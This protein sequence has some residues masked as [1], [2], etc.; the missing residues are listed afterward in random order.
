MLQIRY[1]E[2]NNN[3]MQRWK[4]EELPGVDRRE[5]QLTDLRSY[6][7]Y[8]VEMAA[9]TIIGPG[10]FSQPVMVRPLEDGLFSVFS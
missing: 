10:P 4:E 9:F 2:D 6:S 5:V 7:Q 3:G 8:K 1:V